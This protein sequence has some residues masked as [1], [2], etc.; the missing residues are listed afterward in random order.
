MHASILDRK[1]LR[2]SFGARS[3]RATLPVLAVLAGAVGGCAKQKE[4]LVIVA[5][6]SADA[7]AAT[8]DKV[9]LSIAGVVKTYSS[10]A[11][12]S[13][14]P[15]NFGVYLPASTTGIL[16]VSASASGGGFCFSGSTT[17]TV[18]SAGSTVMVS[19]ALTATT[20]CTGNGGSGGGGTSGTGG[21]AGTGG[22]SGSGGGA[23]RSATGG[24][25]GGSSGSSGNAGATGTGGGSGGA[26]GTGGGSG[27]ATGTGGGSGGATGTGGGSGGATGTGGG[28]G[29]ATGTGG[30][31]GGGGVG[32]VTPPSLT[33]CTEYDHNDVGDPPCDDNLGISNWE[34]WSLAFSPDG[35]LLATAGDDGRVKIWNFD[36]HTL[37]ASGHVISTNGQTY[38]A[39]SPDG[40]TLVA[41]SNG[42]LVTYKTAS[43]TLGPAFTGV[44]GQVRGVAVS[45][46]SQRI[47]TI[48]AN[49]NLYVHTLVSGGTPVAYTLPVYPLSL[50]LEAGS[51]A[52]KIVGAVGFDTGRAATFQITGSTISLESAFTV[53]TST[54]VDV[55]AAA[56]A[57]TGTLLALGDDDGELKF[58]ANPVSNT[59]ATGTALAFATR[60]NVNAV[61]GLSWSRDGAY[62][63]I[64]AGT[65]F[66][67]G[68]ASIYAYPARAQYASVVP[69]YYPVSVAFSP[70]GSALA[71]GEVTCGKVMLC[72]D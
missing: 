44:T 19:L 11:G 66:S 46:D 59:T 36:G 9:A 8:A 31:A 1:P 4:S 24:A 70:S 71:I 62:L 22:F 18:P 40:S 63:A 47:V 72:S 60:G 69:T 5:L 37:T 48:D 12:L 51:S 41:G 38:V 61:D 2:T 33:A 54:S 50:S 15:V 64:A 20:G 56:F 17:A 39:F 42:A 49:D 16:T 32:A 35:R 27:G 10:P 26:T 52:T 58:W 21:L 57:P 30:A 68:S 28:S 13:Q 23:G 43:W 55:L 67:G 25:A 34:I 7:R 53:E 45:A 29:G 65:P 14:T 6:T 3:L